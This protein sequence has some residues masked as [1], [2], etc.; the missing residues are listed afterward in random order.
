MN[1]S[2]VR[3]STPGGYIRTTYIYKKNG[4]SGTKTMKNGF[5]TGSTKKDS[6]FCKNNHTQKVTGSIF[7]MA[8]NLVTC[9]DLPS[10]TVRTWYRTY[11]NE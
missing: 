11:L 9:S 3:I 2:F 1:Y 5:D 7:K 4:T 10:A 8:S 6:T